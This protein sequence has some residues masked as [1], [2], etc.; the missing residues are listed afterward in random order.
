MEVEQWDGSQHACVER[1]F[2]ELVN[3][4]TPIEMLSAINDVNVMLVSDH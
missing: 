1:M 3:A 2:R 4:R